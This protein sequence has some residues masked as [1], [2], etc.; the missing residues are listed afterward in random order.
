MIVF[1]AL[2]RI[3]KYYYPATRDGNVI[4]PKG[5]STVPTE[6]GTCSLWYTTHARTLTNVSAICMSIMKIKLCA[7]D[8]V[9]LFFYISI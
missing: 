4:F 1:S 5:T 3:D 2:V 8:C 9:K 7:F 6:F